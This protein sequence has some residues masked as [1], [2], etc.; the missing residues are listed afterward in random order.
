MCPKDDQ[1]QWLACGHWLH[2]ECAREEM[3]VGEFDDIASIRCGEC[4]KRGE[5]I[6]R[7]AASLIPISDPSPSVIAAALGNDEEV[8]EAGNTLEVIEAGR[9]SERFESGES[10]IGREVVVEAA[11]GKGKGKGKPPMGKGK[12]RGK[13]EPPTGKGKEGP[14]GGKGKIADSGPA[15]WPSL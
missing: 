7:E 6:R 11:R 13:R 8:N 10:V 9:D 4:K 15:L 2:I 12:A 5:Q 14:T 3:R 1:I